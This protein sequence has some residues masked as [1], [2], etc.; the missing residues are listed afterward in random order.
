MLKRSLK[1]AEEMLDAESIEYFQ[2]E[3]DYYNQGGLM[4]QDAFLPQ[5]HSR[6]Q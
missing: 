2:E 5:S 6:T 1:D 3:E 4:L